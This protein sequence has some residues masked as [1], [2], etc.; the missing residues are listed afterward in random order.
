MK[1]IR[2]K[3]QLGG[4]YLLADKP[5]TCLIN[6]YVLII[7]DILS[8]SII[9]CSTYCQF[10]C[11]SVAVLISKKCREAPE[12]TAAVKRKKSFTLQ[13]IQV[14]RQP[15]LHISWC[16]EAVNVFTVIT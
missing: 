14:T 7:H 13:G 5:S 3:W 11:G 12:D 10:T 9:K 15:I 4:F 2:C 6:I 1:E 8:Q 16:W